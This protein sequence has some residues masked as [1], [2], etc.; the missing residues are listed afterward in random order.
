MGTMNLRCFTYWFKKFMDISTVVIYCWFE[1]FCRS[2][3]D[4]LKGNVSVVLIRNFFHA[5]SSKTT[6]STQLFVSKLMKLMQKWKL[7]R[8]KVVSLKDFFQL[9][10]NSVRKWKANHILVKSS[11]RFLKKCGPIKILT[12]K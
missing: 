7:L 4:F 6:W 12:N 5:W 3:I 10:Q 9:R 11:S 1:I 8:N 2:G